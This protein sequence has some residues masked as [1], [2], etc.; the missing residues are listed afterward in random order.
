MAHLNCFLGSGSCL[1]G[2]VTTVLVF[3]LKDIR[4]GYPDCVSVL[5]MYSFSLSF[6]KFFFWHVFLLQQSSIIN[7]FPTNAVQH[8]SAPSL[9]F[10]S[11]HLPNVT[12]N[13]KQSHV[14][15]HSCTCR[16]HTFPVVLVSEMVMIG[17]QDVS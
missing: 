7:L 17:C 2:D 5:E 13:C 12:H 15:P 14:A 1:W 6:N 8:L 11:L 10:A 3:N 16:I 9:L 4:S